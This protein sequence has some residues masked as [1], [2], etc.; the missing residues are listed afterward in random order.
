MGYPKYMTDEELFAFGF[1]VSPDNPSLARHKLY[2]QIS[3][4]YRCSLCNIWAS[5]MG[6]GK[7]LVC[8][9]CH[10]G[11]KP[12]KKSKQ[13]EKL[14]ECCGKHDC[15]T[16]REILDLFKQNNL[17]INNCHDGFGGF[18]QISIPDT[19]SQKQ[20]LEFHVKINNYSVS[21]YGARKVQCRRTGKLRSKLPKS[22][23]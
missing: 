10:K 8:A 16:W 11:G 18:L 9:Q 20:R 2:P 5:S 21:K 12:I 19:W 6:S 4:R 14:Y 23:K 7:E 13:F 3:V 1:A 22:S 15:E 17:P